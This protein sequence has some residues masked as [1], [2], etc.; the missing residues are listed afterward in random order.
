M[1][2]FSQRKL[3]TFDCYGTLIDWESGIF[4]A[5]RPVL[6]AHGKSISDSDLLALYG[7]FEVEAE[8]GGYRSYREVLQSVVRSI[9]H[10][11]GFTPTNE[12]VQLLPD[13]IARWRA[14]PDTVA[15]LNRLATRYRLAIISNIDDE[16]F[17]MTRK[18]LPVNF[19]NVTTAQQARCYKPG[20]EIFRMALSKATVGPDQILHVGQ[21]I[22]HD[23]LPAQSLGLATVWV[24]RPSPRAG[25]GAVKPAAGK[26]D[27]EV[28]DI[29]TLAERA[30]C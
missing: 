20:I 5:L 23:V 7:E 8:A 11:L 25:I 15:G 21:S 22:Y 10:R 3:L 27:L 2:D 6:A 29:A 18:F 13:S 14:W 16:M 24:N 28:P 12:E 1:L 9:G 19:E 30:G 17:A 26:P 4:S